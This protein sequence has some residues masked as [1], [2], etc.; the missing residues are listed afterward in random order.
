MCELAAFVCACVQVQVR[1]SARGGLCVCVCSGVVCVYGCC[2]GGGFV[3]ACLL[4]CLLP[5]TRPSAV[6]Q[7]IHLFVCARARACS[8]MRACERPRVGVWLLVYHPVVG[9]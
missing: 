8:C 1:V 5:S 2:A 6:S 9:I 4:A 3:H 7:Y